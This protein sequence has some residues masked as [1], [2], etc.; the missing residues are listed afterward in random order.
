MLIRLNGQDQ[1][2]RDGTTVM[3]LLGQLKIEGDRVA[4]EVNLM[5]V[6]RARMAGLSLKEGDEVEIVQFVGGG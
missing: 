1:T 5:V 4:V 3:E 6:P 2:I